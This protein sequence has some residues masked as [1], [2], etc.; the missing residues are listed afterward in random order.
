MS[1]SD[2]CTNYR[3]DGAN[4]THT[5]TVSASPLYEA[6]ALRIAEFKKSGFAFANIGP[7]RRLTI[8]V[9]PP[10]TTHELS[11]GKLQAWLELTERRRASRR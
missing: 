3:L 9:E 6:A 7:A 5:V 2:L 10:A 11:V 4:V 1:G 8:A